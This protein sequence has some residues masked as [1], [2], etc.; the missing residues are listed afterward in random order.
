MDSP[1]SVTASAAAAAAVAAAATVNP[2]QPNR[3]RSRPKQ[4]ADKAAKSHQKTLQKKRVREAAKR[5]ALKEEGGAAYEDALKKDS[6]RKRLAKSVQWYRQAADQGDAAAQFQMGV[7]YEYG[8]G[9][10]K[11]YEG[12]VQW[13]RQAADQK[14]AAEQQKLQLNYN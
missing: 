7:A 2:A 9:V 10:E 5:F 12:A 3:S 4:T 11:S 6:K 1:T 8:R 13:Y 14:H